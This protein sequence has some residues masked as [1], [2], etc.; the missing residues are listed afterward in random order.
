MPES[1]E[2]RYNID[3]V[4]ARAPWL[5]SIDVAKRISLVCAILSQPSPSRG[6]EK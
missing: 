2:Q 3:R 4:L 6:N 5:S 1:D